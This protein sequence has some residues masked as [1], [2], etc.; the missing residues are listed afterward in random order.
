[1]IYIYRL[2]ISCVRINEQTNNQTN[3]LTPGIYLFFAHISFKNS[4]LNHFSTSHEIKASL[5]PRKEASLRYYSEYTEATTKLNTQKN[6][7]NKTSNND[8]NNNDEAIQRQ[9]QASTNERAERKKKPKNK[10]TETKVISLV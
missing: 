4:P 1:M 10:T 9:K 5:R 8:N 2:W 7:L 3:K 6:A